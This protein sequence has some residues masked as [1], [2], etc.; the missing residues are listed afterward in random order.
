MQHDHTHTA[1]H[2][3]VALVVVACWRLVLAQAFQMRQEPSAQGVEPD[4][5]TG[6]CI[7]CAMTRRFARWHKVRGGAFEAAST[8]VSAFAHSQ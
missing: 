3:V 6:I 2:L 1:I 5:T 4:F 7:I 8:Q